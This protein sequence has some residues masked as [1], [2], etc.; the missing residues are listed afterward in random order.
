MEPFDPIVTS[1]FELGNHLENM[2]SVHKLG[3]KRL[4]KIL[5]VS[6]VIVVVLACLVPQQT[7]GF[8]LL[9]PFADWMQ[10]SNGFHSGDMGGPMDLG[11][12]YRWN[13]PLLTYSFD[14]SFLDYFGSNG[15][16]AVEEA[17]QTFNELPEASSIDLSDYST[18]G[19]QS[20]PSAEAQQWL[21]L[22]T[23]TL[24]LVL[25]QLGLAQPTRNVFVLR[26][27]DP[28]LQVYHDEMLWPNSP[29]PII[30][31]YVVERNFD[32]ETLAASRRVN[33]SLFGGDVI[34]SSNLDY[35]DVT[36][37]LV[38]PTQFWRSAVGDQEFH[39]GTFFSGLSADDAGGLRYLLH[40]NNVNYETMLPDVRAVTNQVF[41]DSAMRPGVN[42]ITF[43]RQHFDSQLQGWIP[44]TNQFTDTYLTNDEA[45]QQTLERVVAQPDF[46][47]S[48]GDTG[49][50][51]AFSQFVL[52]TGTTNWQN[53]GASDLGPGVVH[54]PVRF[55]FNKLPRT[56]QTFD[57]LGSFESDELTSVRWAS[58]DRTTNS[59]VYPAESFQETNRFVVRF[60]L[61]P[62][63]FEWSPDVAVGEA[64]LLQTSTNLIQWTDVITVTN[65]GGVIEW[66]HQKSSSQAQRFFR[67]IA[68]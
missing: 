50:G 58:F 21:D 38:D 57:Y 17:F 37:R 29:E 63:T 32:P 13:V 14:Q 60:R 33:T 10:P 35:A 55:V 36:E 66:H 54:P 23:A 26:K 8:A 15:V 41:V 61:A 20:L 39:F 27:W 5:I 24:G 67:V 65:A 64:V 31:T 52:R 9:G 51:K 1:G 28:L 25:E 49:D 11:K 68:E 62:S 40:T 30:P 34:W 12:E 6:K 43:V 56:L 7:R 19:P 2:K 46:L 42:K 53:N 3:M 44:A 16:A 48:A 59:A 45:A 22:K 4:T 47:F 18:N